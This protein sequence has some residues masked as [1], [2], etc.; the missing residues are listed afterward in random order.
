MILY[1]E[2]FVV[3]KVREIEKLHESVKGGEDD[4]LDLLQNKKIIEKVKEDRKEMQKIKDTKNV[5]LNHSNMLNES[6]HELKRST[7]HGFLKVNPSQ[8]IIT[9]FDGGDTIFKELQTSPDKR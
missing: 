8:K 4:G 1:E 7:M 3:P 5:D 9:L 2:V 6:E